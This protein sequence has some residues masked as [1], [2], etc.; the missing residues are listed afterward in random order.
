[1]GGK[2]WP[3]KYHYKKDGIGDGIWLVEENDEEGIEHGMD[4]CGLSITL[5]Y[6]TFLN[7]AGG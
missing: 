2:A 7:R 5:L 6:C 1:M 4:R 3:I